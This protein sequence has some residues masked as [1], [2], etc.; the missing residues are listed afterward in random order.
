VQCVSPGRHSSCHPKTTDGCRP[1]HAPYLCAAK[2]PLAARMPTAVSGQPAPCSTRTA[3]Y[4]PCLVCTHCLRYAYTNLISTTRRR[5]SPVSLRPT[6]QLGAGRDTAKHLC[7]Q[8]GADRLARPPWLLPLSECLACA[9]HL[10]GH[11][12]TAMATTI[13]NLQQVKCRLKC[14][15]FPAQFS[16]S[17]VPLS[18]LIRTGPF[19][20]TYRFLPKFSVR[21]V[22]NAE[23]SSPSHLIAP[24]CLFDLFTRHLPIGTSDKKSAPGTTFPI[25]VTA[26]MG[27]FFALLLFLPF[28][29]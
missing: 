1:R 3:P 14:P 12:A 10:T 24:R 26:E 17:C 20:A 29:D 22:F 27:L 8:F 28:F 7:R 16:V 23:D 6:D 25:V 4:Q 9:L 18:E 21:T 2:D 11:A 19:P 5:S 15:N 13:P